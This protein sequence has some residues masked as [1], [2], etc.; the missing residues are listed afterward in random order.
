MAMTGEELGRRLAEI[1][2]AALDGATEVQ[3][4]GLVVSLLGAGL[5]LCDEMGLDRM[6]TLRMAGWVQTEIAAHES[7]SEEPS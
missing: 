1:S 7:P 4:V 6:A 5:H 2:N 3:A